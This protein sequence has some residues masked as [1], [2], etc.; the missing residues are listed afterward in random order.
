MLLSPGSVLAHFL[1]APRDDSMVSWCVCQ[2]L[3]SIA[4]LIT[5]TL[6]KQAKNVCESCRCDVDMLQRGIPHVALTPQEQSGGGKV[7]RTAWYGR[8]YDAV[9]EATYLLALA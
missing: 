5:G 6:A 9:C 8:G 2:Q 7:L 4:L 1:K 3:P